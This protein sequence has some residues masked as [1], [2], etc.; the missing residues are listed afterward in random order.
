MI[1]L[2]LS[3]EK[4]P[5]QPVAASA[6]HKSDFRRLAMPC[7]VAVV[8]VVGTAGAQITV[9]TK[10]GTVT[11]GSEGSA[12]NTV[13]RRYQ[14]ITPT[15]VP[16]TKSE[17]DA[18]TR[19][20]LIRVLESEQ[21]FA[22]RPFPRGHKGLTLAANGK[23]EPAGEGY[24]AMVTS[25]GL[26]AKPGD[27]VVLSD[28]KIEHSRIVFE[29]N[30][31]PDRKH[32]FL[33]HVQ[34]GMGPD[35]TA[36]V[37]QGD[38][39]DPVGARLSLTFQNHVPELTGAEVKALL[40]PL[41]SFDVKTPIQAFTDTLPTK[42]KE[43][44]LDH[45]VLVGM[46]T[47]MVL[48]AKG[49]PDG[50]S[51]EM[52]GQMPFE[53]WI[54]GKP[55]KD[56]EFVRINGNRVIRVEVAKMG[57]TPV[58]FTKDEVEG[59]MRTDGTPLEAAAPNTRVAKVG[60]VERDPDKEAPAPPPSLRNPGEKLPSDNGPDKTGVMKPVQFP[61]P[62]TDPQPGAN[63]DGEPDASPPANAQPA[64]ADASPPASAKPQPPPPDGS[65]Q[66]N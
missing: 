3:Q 48:F 50:K 34:I 29:L 25:E 45:H 57:E 14:Q 65:S 64:P 52:D 42:L 6:N 2:C 20:E 24:V 54:Y 56:V 35:V 9:N 26:S 15:H 55:P 51:R 32:R 8:L 47:D 16:L 33:R 21:G 59:L 37:V 41:I 23:L 31:G 10:T 18:K 49:Q 13:D 27:R 5:T 30:G 43:A 39:P 19:L 22:M 53:E 60:D 61:K 63:P 62:K 66:P 4:R 28:I 58:I 7:A 46:S 1:W 36:P 11:N 38:D 44:I 12:V 40:A 17:L